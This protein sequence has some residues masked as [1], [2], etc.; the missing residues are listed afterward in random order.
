[1]AFALVLAGCGSGN[2]DSASNNGGTEK[3]VLE[4][5]TWTDEEAYM[6]K[7]VEAFNAQ[8]SNIEVNMTT[9]SNDADE[10]NTKIMNNLSGGSKMDVYSM[11]GTSS[12]GLYSSKNQLVD[13]SDRIKAENMDVGAYGPSF[14]D[15]TEVLTSG[16]IT[17]FHTVLPNMHC[18]TTRIFLIRPALRFPRK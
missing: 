9:I 14:Q 10:Y 7:V 4:Y 15:I 2:N 5:Y 12:L 6:K 17:R 1:M 13:L 3:T 8:N 16:K 11:N 18:S